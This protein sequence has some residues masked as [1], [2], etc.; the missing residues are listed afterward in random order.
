MSKYDYDYFSG[1]GKYSGKPSAYAG[2]DKI[3][4][5]NKEIQE[6][7]E[8]KEEENAELAEENKKQL[9]D[10]NT[11][12]KTIEKI[13]GIKGQGKNAFTELDTSGVDY[14]GKISIINAAGNEYYKGLMKDMQKGP[15]KLGKIYPNKKLKQKLEN[16][17]G[18]ANAKKL[19][20][21]KGAFQGGTV[22]LKGKTPKIKSISKLTKMYTKMKVGVKK[23]KKSA[24]KTVKDFKLGQG[25]TKSQANKLL[26]KISNIE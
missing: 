1:S 21:K 15:K 12:K 14:D 25:K 4:D 13:S 19:F 17:M 11:Y 3:Y 9:K 7:L 23:A 24:V 8:E 6:E 26:T 5:Q 10:I 18:K 22:K 2:Q 16:F 20:S